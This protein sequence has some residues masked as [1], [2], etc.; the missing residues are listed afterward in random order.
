MVPLPAYMPPCHV[1]SLHHRVFFQVPSGALLSLQT[2]GPG[3]RKGLTRRRAKESVEEEAARLGGG[4]G[5]KGLYV[6]PSKALEVGGGFYVPGLEGYRLRL[7]IVGLI[8]TLLSLNRLLLPGFTP[9]ANQ[10][11]SESITVLTAVFV[12]LQALF[13]ATFKG[14]AGEAESTDATPAAGEAEV[15]STE[16]AMYVDPALGAEQSER[17]Q[18]LMGA[19]LQTVQAGSS[20]LVMGTG[21][22]VAASGASAPSSAQVR[23]ELILAILLSSRAFFCP[24]HPVCVCVCRQLHVID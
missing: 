7:A 2:V 1:A 9:N 8:L 17:L 19:A 3:S 16:S 24:L 15:G 22:R 12:L 6:R 5:T 20:T 13:D 23:L 11:V 14:G 10:V 4:R 18:W 21:S